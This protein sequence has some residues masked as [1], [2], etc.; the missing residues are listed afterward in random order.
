M[1][2]RSP[3]IL[4]SYFI[5]IYANLFQINMLEWLEEKKDVQL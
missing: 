1:A 2:T 5:Q 4:E 3:A